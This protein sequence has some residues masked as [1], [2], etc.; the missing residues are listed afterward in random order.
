[1]LAMTSALPS[2]AV[3]L[4]A[5]FAPLLCRGSVSAGVS[6]D[7]VLA[8]SA[9]EPNAIV[10]Y[11]AAPAQFAELWLP[12]SGDAAPLIIFI[13]GGCWLNA[14]AI[15]HSHALATA[16]AQSGYA[17][18]NIEYRRV[19][20]ADGGW[21]GSFEDIRAALRALVEHQ[22]QG[23]DLRRVMLVGHSAGG[24]LALLA[25][26]SLLDDP[27]PGLELRGVIGLAAITDIAAYAMEEGSCPAAASEF[28]GG[29]PAARADAYRQANPA[30]LPVH[31]DT[32][33][34]LGTSDRIIPPAQA[35]LPVRHVHWEAAGHFDW[36]HPGTPAWR[37]FLDRLQRTLQ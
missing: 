18:W 5:L 36:I 20:D 34:M 10:H 3:L 15:D 23:V 33:L 35:R 6:F 19:G 9:R 16:L 11:G 28:M 25:G 22:P 37:A 7:Q 24:H 26:S 27:V 31:P 21:P 13:H 14:Y 2:R 17:L 12:G 29:L 1:M 32:Y 8:V 4:F 30:R